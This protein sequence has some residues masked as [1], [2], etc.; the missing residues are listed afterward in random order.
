MHLEAPDYHRNP[1]DA[2][3]SLVVTEW[4]PDLCDFLYRASGLTTTAILIQDYETGPCWGVLRS[5]Y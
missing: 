3:R 1:I 2:D 4:G 5:V